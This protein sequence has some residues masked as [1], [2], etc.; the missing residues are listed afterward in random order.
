MPKVRIEIFEGGEPSATIT[1][2]SWLVTGA[3]DLLPG[4]VGGRLRDSVELD[5]IARLLKDPNATGQVLEVE[6]HAANERI[7]I[8]IVA[9]NEAVR[10]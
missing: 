5:Q 8:S 3:S 4:L 10:R 9:D 2:P 1:V 7:V 6:D